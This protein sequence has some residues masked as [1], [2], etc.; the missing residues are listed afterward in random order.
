MD[1]SLVGDLRSECGDALR[2]IGTYDGDGYRVHYL[3][4]DVDSNLDADDLDAIREGAV[5]DT[6]QRDYYERLFS[7][8]GSFEATVRLFERALIVEVPNGAGAGVMVS[9]DRELDAPARAV[10]ERCRDALE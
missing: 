5:L 9:L 2:A 1:D 4:D 7:T 6:L 10:V 3:R 8:A